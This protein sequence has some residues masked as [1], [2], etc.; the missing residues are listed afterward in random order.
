[1]T[2]KTKT[3]SIRLNTEDKERLSSI[4]TRK[5]LESILGQIERGEIEITAEGVVI[6]RV[7][8]ISDSVNTYEYDDPDGEWVREMAHELNMDVRTFKRTI[9]KSK[10]W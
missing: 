1:M 2:N 8:T 9:E 3:L 4:I 5:S 10:G 6:K 7:N